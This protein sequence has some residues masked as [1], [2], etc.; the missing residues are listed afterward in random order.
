MDHKPQSRTVVMTPVYHQNGRC[1]I[2]PEHECLC[3]MLKGHDF[4]CL[5]V[6]LSTNDKMIG[7]KEWSIDPEKD[8]A[9]LDANHLCHLLGSCN[10][11]S[12]VCMRVKITTE[13]SE[14]DADATFCIIGKEDVFCEP[15][16]FS[17]M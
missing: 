13:Y 2:V 5:H 17:W 1:C 4:E 14:Y 15:L 9:C 12:E 8:Y 3:F 6:Q 16:V 11:G 10:P 7:H